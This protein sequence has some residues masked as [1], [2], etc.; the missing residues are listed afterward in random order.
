MVVVFNLAHGKMLP[1]LQDA[2]SRH[3]LDRRI[4][5]RHVGDAYSRGRSGEVIPLWEVI[6]EAIHLMFDVFVL[7]VCVFLVKVNGFS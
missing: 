1:S 7:C 3:C 5:Y 2:L 4:D 6:P